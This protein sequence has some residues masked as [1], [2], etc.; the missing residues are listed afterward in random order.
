MQRRFLNLVMMDMR[1]GG[2]YWLSRMNPEENLFYSSAKEAVAQ[3][4]QQR[5]RGRD[6][7]MAESTLDLP[8]PMMRF[9]SSRVL[10]PTL[11]FLPFYGL[12]GSRVV[13]ADSDGGTLL[14]DAQ[15]DFAEILPPINNGGK[16]LIPISLCVTNPN[17]ADA[18]Y[19]INRPNSGSF[20]SLALLYGT[21]LGAFQTAPIG[22]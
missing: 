6:K 15:D 4:S 21:D 8:S 7:N 14:Y 22:S 5:R 20:K 1:A 3:D 2:S 13:V 11:A 12:T 17:K 18:L 19:A 10:D 9:R 16:W